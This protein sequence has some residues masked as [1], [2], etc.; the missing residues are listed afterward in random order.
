MHALGGKEFVEFDNPYD[1]GM[2]GL[3][4]FSSGYAAMM[5]CDTLLMLGTGF[6]YKQFYPQDA[7]IAQV[8]LRPAE[9]GRRCR[10]ELG[11]VGDVGAT[12]R[13]LLPRLQAKADRA[14]LD[15]SLQALREGPAGPRRTGDRASRAARCTRNTSPARSARRPRTT[16]CSPPM[17]ARRRSGRRAIS[18]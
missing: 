7:Q 5:A 16:R 11:L 6:P 1:V 8:D 17:S 10:I 9:L 2:T 4:G 15:A 14:F 18:R 12:L 3:I 13:A